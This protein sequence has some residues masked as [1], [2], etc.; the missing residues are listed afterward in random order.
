MWWKTLYLSLYQKS[1]AYADIS[2][3]KII[4]KTWQTH[5]ETLCVIYAQAYWFSSVDDSL[6]QSPQGGVGGGP[7]FIGGGIVSKH[8]FFKN[9]FFNILN[10]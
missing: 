4:S 7:G 3:K 5:L 1:S 9:L 8:F 2:S 6:R 10:Y